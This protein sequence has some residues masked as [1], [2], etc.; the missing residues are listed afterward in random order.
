MKQ[1]FREKID[2]P[3]S[4]QKLEKLHLRMTVRAEEIRKAYYSDLD[5][6]SHMNNVC[7]I[8]WIVDILPIE[9]LKEKRVCSLQINSNASIMYNDEVRVIMDQDEK[10]VYYVA[11]MSIDGR[12]NYFTAEVILKNR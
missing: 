11:G 7:Y 1:T 4:G 12:K 9:L 3:Y 6:N 2:F 5:I 10:D 8:R